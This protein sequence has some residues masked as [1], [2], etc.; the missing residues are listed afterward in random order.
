MEATIILASVLCLI[1]GAGVGYFLRNRTAQ[2]ELAERQANGDKIIEKV[3]RCNTEGRQIID[4]IIIFSIDYDNLDQHFII[5]ID[6][7]DRR[8]WRVSIGIKGSG[9][10][11][12]L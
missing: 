9:E 2:A 6:D 11:D 12:K 10:G 7:I 5:I 4:S 3:P 1:V 8:W